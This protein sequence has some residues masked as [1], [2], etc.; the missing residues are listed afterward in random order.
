[1]SAEDGSIAASITSV[2]VPG[3]QLLDLFVLFLA[4]PGPVAVSEPPP[5]VAK[6]FEGPLGWIPTWSFERRTAP[7]PRAPSPILA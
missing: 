2:K 4:T 6:V 7:A 5:A 1:M 3:P